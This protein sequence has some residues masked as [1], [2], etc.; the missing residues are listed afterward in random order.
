MILFALLAISSDADSQRLWT[1]PE[2]VA[3]YDGP[4]GGPMYAVRSAEVIPLSLGEMVRRSELIVEA[5]L[6]VRRTY[7]SEGE[8]WI[9]TEYD[10]IPV[11]VFV[12]RRGQSAQRPGPQSLILRQSGGRMV[13]SGRDVIAEET[14]FR[15]LPTNEPI[16]LFLS[17]KDRDGYYEVVDGAGAV[18]VRDSHVK[19][20]LQTAPG[21]NIADRAS[22][23]GRINREL[24]HAR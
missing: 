6:R 1:I 22:L 21:L 12:N 4:P 18:T 13:V 5:T 23:I 19:P 15:L 2:S 9:H 7:L 3:R 10:V 16:F 11:M 20:W 17:D 8:T 24:S 14:Q